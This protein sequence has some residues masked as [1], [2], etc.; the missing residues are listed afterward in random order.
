M[1][2]ES[3]DIFTL[4]K[5]A[6]IAEVTSP[7]VRWVRTQNETAVAHNESFIPEFVRDNSAVV[8]VR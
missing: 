1:E 7:I 3:T 2:H 5:D 8:P 6:S 4:F